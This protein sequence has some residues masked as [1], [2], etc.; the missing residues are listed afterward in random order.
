MPKFP[1]PWFR[2]SRGVWYVTLGGEQINLGADRTAAFTEYARLMA[3]PTTSPK[4]SA[5]SLVG[6]IDAFLEWVK[7]ERSDGTYGWF[8]Y[9]LE[10]FARK[11]PDMRAADV[12]PFHVQQ[13]VDG[14]PP[15]LSVA[16][17][18]ARISRPYT[19]L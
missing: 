11:Y 7:R 9:R 3:E 16:L 19:R 6:I 17:D 10:R 18:I 2:P 8:Q 13:W 1:K 14:Y 15:V 5:D 4:V 12:R